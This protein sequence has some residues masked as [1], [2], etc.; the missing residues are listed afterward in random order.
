MP[1]VSARSAAL[2]HPHFVF[3]SERE[4]NF[5]EETEGTEFFFEM[6]RLREQRSERGRAWDFAGRARGY[7]G[8]HARNLL[9]VENRFSQ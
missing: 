4:G 5:N 9:L 7:L 3:E 6:K 1:A 2:I 8:S